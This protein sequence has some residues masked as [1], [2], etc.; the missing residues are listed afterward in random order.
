MLNQ[1]GST[2]LS[3]RVS[4]QFFLV[5]IIIIIFFFDAMERAW[6][7]FLQY[8]LERLIYRKIYSSQP[9]LVWFNLN[10]SCWM[11]WLDPLSSIT[12]VAIGFEPNCCFH[13]TNPATWMLFSW[14]FSP[15]LNRKDVKERDIPSEYGWKQSKE[16][17]MLKK[18]NRKNKE[19]IKSGLVWK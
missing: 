19:Q 11:P 3:F 14:W 2:R 5:F 17:E 10:R 6:I 18:N 16:K 1:R 9:C 4:P 12:I 7:E 13:L 15:W 8:A